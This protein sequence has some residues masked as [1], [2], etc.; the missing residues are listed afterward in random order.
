MEQRQVQ[1]RGL[2]MKILAI[3]GCANRLGSRPSSRD[4]LVNAVIEARSPAFMYFKHHRKQGSQ[5]AP[6][7][8]TL[9]RERVDLCRHLGLL[10]AN[11]WT[12]TR[13]GQAALQPRKFES[14][15]IAQVTNLLAEK[16]YDLSRTPKAL[17]AGSVWLPTSKALYEL[18][19]GGLRLPDF[20]RLLSLLG[21]CGYFTV[22]QSRI[23]LPSK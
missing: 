21:E 5:L 12:L 10:D 19:E 11:N 13:Q 4:A 9:V 23:Y 14:T 1:P 7:S 15:L 18:G 2:Y 8:E 20:R 16:G 3:I 17:A 22:V 6:C